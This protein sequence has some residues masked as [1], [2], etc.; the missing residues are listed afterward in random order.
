[1]K[2]GM[3]AMIVEYNIIS[4]LDTLGITSITSD[5]LLTYIN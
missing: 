1:M 2:N 5:I 3:T 4:L